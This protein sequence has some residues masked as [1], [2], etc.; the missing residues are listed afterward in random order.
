MTK[1]IGKWKLMMNCDKLARRCTKIAGTQHGSAWL[2]DKLMRFFE[3]APA[4]E[5][6]TIPVYINAPVMSEGE[7]EFSRDGSMVLRR[8]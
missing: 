3:S 8:I 2:Y 7:A 5:S 4:A 6:I 1:E